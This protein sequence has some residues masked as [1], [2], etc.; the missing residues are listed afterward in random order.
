M[1]A[2]RFLP[3]VPLA[4]VAACA[5]H[6]G[7]ASQV[8]NTT[9]PR[10]ETRIEVS[11]GT[12]GHADYVVADLNGDQ[13][14]DM[15]VIGITGELQVMIGNNATW[16]PG[17]T[18]QLGGAPVWIDKGDF[19]R[20]GDLDLAVIRTD[21]Q[22]ATVLFNDGNAQ[23]SVGPSLPIGGGGVGIVVGD[24]DADGRLDVVVSRPSAPEI[25]VFL[26]DGNGAFTPGSSLSLPA[27][28]PLGGPS[29]GGSPFT[30]ALG[31]VTRDQVADLVVCDPQM[32][33]V[34]VF[35]GLGGGK[36]F[37]P[38]PTILPMP[39]EPAASSIG[40]LDGDGLADIAVSL[41][42]TNQF[43]VVTSFAPSSGTVAFDSF[44]LAVD[45][46]PTISTIGD[47]TGDGLAD[48]VGCLVADAAVVVAP[49]LVGGGLGAPFRLDATGLPL[50]PFLGDADRNG[51]T[52]LFVLS[53]FGDRVNLW[54]AQNSGRLV[55]ARSHASGLAASS[56]VTAADFDRD[57]FADVAAGGSADAVQ[58]LRRNAENRLVPELQIP[59]GRPVFNVRR[60]DLDG[61]GRDDL[62]VPVDNGVK[63]LRNRSTAGTF[64]F[65]VLPG[66]GA[67][68]FG[69]G[70]GPFGVVA[71][72]FDRDGRLDLA[73]ADYA[74]GTLQVLR[75]G[76]DP[77]SFTT[78]RNLAIGGGPVDVAAA[79]F[80]GDGIVDI[81]VS[82]AGQSDILVFANDGAANFTQLVSLPVGVAPLYLITADFD[83]NGRSDLVVSNGASNDVSVLFS[84]PTG[85][86]TTTIPA[87]RTPTALL[88][89]DL[90][91]DGLPDVLVASLQGGDFRVL[92][93]DPLRPGNF[94]NVFPF[95]GTL[96]ASGAALADVDGDGDRDLLITSLISSR[97]SL[98][99]NVS[100]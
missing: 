22:E 70:V 36:D 45:G 46:A 99:V 34:V 88:G 40:D 53:G 98:V 39:G 59:I 94:T 42:D 9:T 65:D 63:V 54:L 14:L 91:N 52:D 90:T 31:D 51:R 15:A 7:D 26:G 87:G 95:P 77:F 28:S 80:N 27:G 47:V 32:H 16:T 92:V 35:W 19:D 64:A 82:R 86:T 55:G 49:Q 58:I 1:S 75:G 4:L 5:D 13:Q 76:N 73:M 100:R 81:A 68:S 74:G 11:T 10:F 50:R 17:Q 37:D 20:D 18:L 23:F 85:F 25:M 8:F 72:D 3:F 79:D 89:E 21:A 56:F 67:S 2:P 61:D 38:D 83:R 30:M 43:V 41:F 12:L 29:S 6:D 66:S 62:L 93:N 44:A 84:T 69:S 96:G 24:A 48:L 78:L 33:R 57:G 71:A 97:I 60:A